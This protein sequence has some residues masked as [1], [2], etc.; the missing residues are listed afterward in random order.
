MQC[1]DINEEAIE[2]YARGRKSC[3][4]PAL[5]RHLCECE[6]CRAR[7]QETIEWNR[8]LLRAEAQR[9]AECA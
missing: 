6:E 1:C 9:A 2:I 3:A 4:D 7:L 5:A 8:Q